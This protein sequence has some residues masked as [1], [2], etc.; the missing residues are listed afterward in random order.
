M[1]GERSTFRG[2]PLL[3]AVFFPLKLAFGM[4]HNVDSLQYSSIHS[5]I[6]QSF[7]DLLFFIISE[8]WFSLEPFL[9]CVV[10]CV[11][12]NKNNYS[13]SGYETASVV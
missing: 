7:I 3:A 10:M 12:R 6:S 2:F 11:E 9:W 1:G 8:I 5:V 4:T 13:I